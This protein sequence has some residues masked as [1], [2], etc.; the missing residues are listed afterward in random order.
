MSWLRTRALPLIAAALALGAASC[1]AELDLGEVPAIDF[2]RVTLTDGSANRYLVC[3]EDVCQ[4]TQ[5][6]RPSPVF[7]VSADRL[8]Y[9]WEQI[10]ARAPRTTLFAEDPA[11]NQVDYVQRSAVIGFP[12]VITVRFVA[13]GP[14]R[15]TLA[16]LSRSIYGRSDFGINRARIEDWLKQ[17][18][19]AMPAQT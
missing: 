15:S 18:A 9:E 16:I 8:R 2:Q 5:A 11:L 14:N 12:D 6:H 10:V 1:S 4:R 13:L 3:N 7:P 17:L 19:A